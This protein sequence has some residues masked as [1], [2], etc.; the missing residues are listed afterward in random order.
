MIT[1]T[2]SKLHKDWYLVLDQRS[3]RTSTAVIV[4]VEDEDVLSVR[5]AY[6]VSSRYVS[7]SSIG[8]PPLEELIEIANEET[9]GVFQD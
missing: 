6:P 9:G 7:A 3:A 2:G 5:V 8:H 1:T 4:R